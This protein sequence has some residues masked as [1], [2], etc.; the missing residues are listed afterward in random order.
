MDELYRARLRAEIHAEDRAL[1]ERVELLLESDTDL[2]IQTN[3]GFT[4]LIKAS[5]IRHIKIVDFY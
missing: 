3:D 1:E 5:Q 2:N 4:A